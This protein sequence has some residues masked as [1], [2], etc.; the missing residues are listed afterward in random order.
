MAPETDKQSLLVLSCLSESVGY[1]WTAV[2]Y[3]QSGLAI[4]ATAFASATNVLLAQ[5]N[6]NSSH[7]FRADI[8]YDSAKYLKTPAEYEIDRGITAASERNDED[9]AERR[10]ECFAGF[11]LTRTVI[12]RLIP[13]NPQLDKP[14]LQTCHVYDAGTSRHLVVY[15]PHVSS[16][17]ATPWYHP[18][19]RALAYLYETATPDRGSHLNATI[20]VHILPFEA[21]ASA[22][23]IP[24]R[25]HRTIL[26]LL[27]T[28]IR[29]TKSMS[30]RPPG[31]SP[32]VAIAPKDNIIPQHI[33]QN[34]YSRLKQTYSTDLINRWVEKTE[35]SKHVF[36]DLSIAAFLIELWRQMY[37]LVPSCERSATATYNSFP[38][39][40][41]IACGN[42]VL[43]YV[44]RKEGY[45]GWGFDARRRRTW[46]IFPEA[47]RQHL[48]ER[49]LVPEPYLRATSRVATRENISTG[50][51]EQIQDALRGIE[52]HDGIFEAGTFIV[53]NHADE[54]T[55]W[56]PILAALSNANDPL[57]WLAIP[58][59]SHALSGARYRYPLA[60]PVS[61]PQT[62]NAMSN[63]ADQIGPAPTDI[64]T[65]GDHLPNN[66]SNGPN[67]SSLSTDTTTKHT[68]EQEQP[69]TGDLKA[70]RAAKE[71]AASGADQSSM[72]ACLTAK[73]VALAE[74]LGIETEK[75]LMRIPSTRNI[76][77]LGGRRIAIQKLRSQIGGKD[78]GIEQRQVEELQE[79][80]GTLKVAGE[81]S[82]SASTST[83]GDATILHNREHANR[84]E[85]WS[86]DD[87]LSKIEEVIER[88]CTAS[89][90][91]EAAAQMWIERAKSLQIG[92]GR[93][94]VNAGKA[95]G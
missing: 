77:I 30:Q 65:T 62:P 81:A 2:E 15:Q 68:G 29:L 48:L 23:T 95:H 52:Y 37:G 7:L 51:P 71:K 84:R 21:H 60:K 42:G 78:E 33:V 32:N 34:T 35:P 49:V 47:V 39:F 13:R 70:L 73:V 44:L 57:P 63:L 36:E 86:E 8:L 38:G 12:R 88:E 54:L 46:E 45:D 9:V 56:T 82:A 4:S 67:R 19:I 76:G 64:M 90:G 72:Y 85:V 50:H 93:G 5:P 40:V 69:A 11:T 80:L 41:D 89:G 24:N 61:Q 58:C 92:Q 16:A 31:A 14:L 25:L 87:I 53:S 27:H 3:K 94:K 91:V 59:C 1:W 22:T 83:P 74:E 26:S 10:P 18:P 28:L 43:V 17:E 6:L 75:T 20:S 79:R 66:H 55:P